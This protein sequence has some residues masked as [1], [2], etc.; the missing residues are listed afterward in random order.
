MSSQN[1]KFPADLAA[2]RA[3][4]HHQK[5]DLSIVGSGRDEYW[6]DPESSA[7]DDGN[8]VFKPDNL[9]ATQPGRWRRHRQETPDIAAARAVTVVVDP[10]GQGDASTIQA[11]LDLLPAGGGTVLLKPGT[12]AL[13]AALQLPDKPVRI[14]AEGPHATRHD[15]APPVVI[16]IGANVIATVEIPAGV[17]ATDSRVWQFVGIGFTAGGVAGQ[18]LLKNL[19]AEDWNPHVELISCHVAGFEHLVHNAACALYVHLVNCRGYFP[20]LATA[21]HWFDAG[22]SD[23]SYLYL[24]NSAFGFDNAYTTRGGVQGTATLIVTLY[25]A[26]SVMG[27]GVNSTIDAL[28]ARD[29]VLYLENGVTLTVADLSVANLIISSDGASDIAVA[30]DDWYCVRAFNID[31]PDVD[32][33]VADVTR[34]FIAGSTFAA[35]NVGVEPVVVIN[36]AGGGGG[37]GDHGVDAD[38]DGPTVGEGENIDLTYTEIFDTDGYLASPASTIAIPAGQGGKYLVAVDMAVFPESTKSGKTTVEIRKNASAI[39]YL[40]FYP[41]A[42]QCMSATWSRVVQFAESDV[43]TVNVFN[44]NAAGDGDISVYYNHISLQRLA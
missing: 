25:G 27:I 4:V 5:G 18:D 37:V 17:A 31:A 1:P 30:G 2:L 36:S 23:Y 28:D 16:D 8:L 34:G 39:G 32:L 21:R 15:D 9:L 22:T 29:G 41:T 26:E 6:F 10:A 13:T 42:D 11:G 40:F 44:A 14:V 12:Y 35:I 43:I 3:L 33:T 7:A 19:A 24:I 38:G 20:A